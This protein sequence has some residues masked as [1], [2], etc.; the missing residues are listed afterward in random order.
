M[1][2]RP[3]FGIPARTTCSL[4]GTCHPGKLRMSAWPRDIFPLKKRSAEKVPLS[5][6]LPPFPPVPLPLILEMLF[7]H[8]FS[9]WLL[10]AGPGWRAFGLGEEWGR[11]KPSGEGRRCGSSAWASLTAV[12]SHPIACDAGGGQGG[13][14]NPSKG[15]PAGE[16]APL[17]P[18]AA[19]DRPKPPFPSGN[20]VPFEE[21]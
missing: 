3:A 6:C 4:S 5:L 19:P 15:S 17:P 2:R 18:R 14:R 8:V 7:F 13:G 20:L 21:S 16:L 11:R 9:D 12:A 1:S 10:K